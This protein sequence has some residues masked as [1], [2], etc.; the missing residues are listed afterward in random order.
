[1]YT[2]ATDKTGTLTIRLST[3]TLGWLDEEAVKRGVARGQVARRCIERVQTAADP[4]ARDAPLASEPWCPHPINRRRQ[5]TGLCE[6]CGRDAGP[7]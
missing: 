5:G 3:Q 7:T 2:V 1:V 4:V 6:M